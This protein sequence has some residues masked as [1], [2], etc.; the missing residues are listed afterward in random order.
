[1]DTLPPIIHY[2]ERNMFGYL[3]KYML[4]SYEKSEFYMFLNIVVFDIASSY[5][6]LCHCFRHPK[7]SSAVHYSAELYAL[8]WSS[9]PL[10]CLMNWF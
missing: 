6:W 2:V 8:Y 4:L 3:L 9:Q 7:Y 5:V 1:M 10:L